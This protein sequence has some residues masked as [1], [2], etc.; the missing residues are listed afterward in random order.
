M[1]KLVVAYICLCN[2]L[3]NKK[4]RFESHKSI[5]KQCYNEKIILN[6]L[7]KTLEP[8]IEN[9]YDEFNTTWFDRS[10]IFFWQK[11]L[12]AQF[13]HIVDK[14]VEK[15]TFEMP[16]NVC[17]WNKKLQQEEQWTIYEGLK[18]NDESNCKF[19]QQKNIKKKNF[20]LNFI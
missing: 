13:H 7:C 10:N 5:L 19:V 9:L 8:S 2:F 15:V 11:S 4:A 17:Q 16:A 20:I 1:Q 14:R 18:K 3:Q 12:T 6:G